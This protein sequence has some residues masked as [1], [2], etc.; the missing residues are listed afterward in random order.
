[1]KPNKCPKILGFVPQTPLASLYSP[2][3]TGRLT[4]NGH[5]TA[6]VS[7]P[8]KRRGDAQGTSRETRLGTVAPQPTQY[9]LSGSNQAG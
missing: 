2:S 3:L 7:P 9:I 1:M 5:P 6:G 8:F 4:A